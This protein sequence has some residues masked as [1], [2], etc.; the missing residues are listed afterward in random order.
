MAGIVDLNPV[1][2]SG[3]VRPEVFIAGNNVGKVNGLTLDQPYNG[4]HYFNIEVSLKEETNTLLDL[5]SSYI[6]QK[7][8]I[9]LSAGYGRTPG[10]LEFTG[11]VTNVKLSKHENSLMQLVIQ[12]YSPTRLMDDGPHHQSWK[13][14]TL[15]DIVGAVTMKY[16]V[17]V[18][19]DISYA[20]PIPYVNQYKESTW[21]F[22]RRKMKTYGQWCYYDGEQ[23]VVGTPPAGEELTL[24]FG[25]EMT[26][27]DLSANI[28]PADFKIMGYNYVD[29]SHFDSEGSSV[30]VSSFDELG[31][32][33]MGAAT[34]VYK[35]KPLTIEPYYTTDK[36]SLESHAIRRR[37]GKGAQFVNLYGQSSHL[38]L[39][40]G[41]VII[42]K[43]EDF[44]LGFG[45]GKSD[46][47]SYRIVHLNHGVDGLGNYRNSFQAIPA[48]LEVPP[49]SEKDIIP[50]HAETQPA[51]VLDNNDPEGLGRVQV[52][53][54]WQKEEGESTPWI[55]VSTAGAG[56]A[57]GNYFVPEVGDSVLVGFTW[58]NPDRPLVV[59]S[60]YNSTSKHAGAHDPEN[61]SKIIKTRSGNKITLSDKGG[62]E[63]I[64]IE[65]GTNVIT[66]SLDG[67]TTIK[68][69]TAG[70]LI[71]HGKTVAIT[72]DESFTLNSATTQM[73]SSET[74]N[75]NSGTDMALDSGAN[76][77]L[78][79]SDN[80]DIKGTNLTASADTKAE[81]SSKDT[82]ISGVTKV[83]VSG[84]MVNIN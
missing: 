22:L 16:D 35:N 46:Y 8:S 48:T 74:T 18:S 45:V 13:E 75:I 12:G 72:A 50:P 82:A 17:A 3:K 57:H 47:G 58:N 9:M 43:A 39:K 81:V 24:T 52:Q 54:P 40:L 60:L 11:F 10:E 79:A 80:V 2:Q 38:G 15:D 77:T 23:L 55:R 59:G 41:Q 37:S 76:A 5:S 42:V 63:S 32:L 20:E 31:N 78:N 27:L 70:D 28:V 30:E 56:G 25:K 36:T 71:M 53:F 6:G 49:N 51:E 68:I 67:N 29:D 64:I 62:E 66:M 73:T 33:A 26:A 69:E 21:E 83:D 65:N 1:A 4:H 34:E 84:G 19:T 44:A 61:N 7:I 14:K